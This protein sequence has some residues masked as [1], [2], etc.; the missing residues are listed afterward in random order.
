MSSSTR[1]LV[2]YANLDKAIS[3]LQHK[4]NEQAITCINNAKLQ[5]IA[6]IDADKTSTKHKQNVPKFNKNKWAKKL[7]EVRAKFNINQTQ[8]AQIIDVSPAAISS[9]ERGLVKP[10][11]SSIKKV[12]QKIKAIM[13]L[14]NDNFTTT[15]DNSDD[16]KTTVTTIRKRMKLTQKELGKL[17]NVTQRTISHWELGQN[18]P[19][20]HRQQTYLNRIRQ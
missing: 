14:K 1:Y 15:I 18:T 9:W 6:I 17:M 19:C 11:D 5:I 13:K 10:H 12:N 7:I 8:L 2:M 3:H 16:W 4:Q 20:I